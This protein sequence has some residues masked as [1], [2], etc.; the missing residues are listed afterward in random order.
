MNSKKSLEKDVFEV[1]PIR[2]FFAVIAFLSLPLM[3]YAHAPSLGPNGGKRV[4]AGAYHVELV[5]KGQ[6][7]DVYVTDE[8]YKPVPVIGYTG[9]AILI[10]DGQRQRINLQPKSDNSLNG[11]S[12]SI[13]GTNFK[14]AVQ[15][16]TPS[17]TMVQGIFE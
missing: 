2:I 7:V 4:D 16:K 8:V 11:V 3:T 9:T 6:Q 5:I 12:S 17:G 1:N 10:T 13:I 14:G 15:I